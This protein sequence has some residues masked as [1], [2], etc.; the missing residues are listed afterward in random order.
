MLEAETIS[1]IHAILDSHLSGKHENEKCFI[2][3][4]W[5]L[6]SRCIASGDGD[7]SLNDANSDSIHGLVEKARFMARVGAS[8]VLRSPP[9][10]QL[11]WCVCLDD[12]QQFCSFA[13]LTF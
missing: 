6:F 2:L 5:L 1:L 12:S 8:D 9:R 3:L 13:S 11:K 4:Q 7:I 10:W